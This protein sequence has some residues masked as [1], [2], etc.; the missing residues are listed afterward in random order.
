MFKEVQ[1]HLAMATHLGYN[2]EMVPEI[3]AGIRAHWGLFQFDAPDGVIINVTKT[4]QHR[5]RSK[6]LVAAGCLSQAEPGMAETSRS[7]SAR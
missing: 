2:E 5:V 1:P 7:M 3:V 4:T 6:A